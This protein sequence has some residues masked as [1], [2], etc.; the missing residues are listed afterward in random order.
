[1]LSSVESDIM[2][3]VTANVRHVGLDRGLDAS[4]EVSERKMTMLLSQYFNIRQRYWR[5]VNALI[6]PSYDVICGCSDA[7]LFMHN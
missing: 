4:R 5:I 2:L 1:M 7:T 3:S 6:A